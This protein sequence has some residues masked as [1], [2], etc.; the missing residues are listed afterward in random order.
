MVACSNQARGAIFSI[1]RRE[2]NEAAGPGGVRPLRRGAFVSDGPPRIAINHCMGALLQ[3]LV[4]AV[5]WRDSEPVI[6]AKAG[7]HEQFGI[8]ID[9]GQCSWIPDQVRDDGYPS[10]EA[11]SD[12]LPPAAVVSMQVTRSV[13]KRAT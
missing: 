8:L 2:T 9:K 7:I 1:R 5:P 10:I 3:R 11:I 12:A 13:A 6:P 4:P